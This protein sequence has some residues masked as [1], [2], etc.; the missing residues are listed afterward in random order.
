MFE[1][2]VAH[3]H[4]AQAI[5]ILLDAVRDLEPETRK[6]WEA[7]L[8]RRIDVG[9][10]GCDDAFYSRWRIG[11][12]LLQRLVEENIHLVVTIYRQSEKSVPS[13]ESGQE[14]GPS[15]KI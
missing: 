11:P 8:E 5:E 7:C 10:T 4:P 12:K 6:I 9:W 2:P 15:P 1:A 3:N 13:D 14:N